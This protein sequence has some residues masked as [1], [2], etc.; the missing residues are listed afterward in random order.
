M[1]LGAPGAGAVPL[2]L[3]V[4][5]GRFIVCVC[6]LL[7]LSYLVIRVAGGGGP[8]VRPGTPSPCGVAAR[9]CSSSVVTAAWRRRAARL[10]RRRT[11]LP[12]RRVGPRRRSRSSSRATSRRSSSSE[13]SARAASCSRRPF[14]VERVPEPTGFRARWPRS[15]SPRTRTCTCSSRRRCGTST[16]RWRRLR[17]ASAAPGGRVLFRVTLPLF[18]PAICRLAPRRPL[19]AVG[20]RRGLADAVRLAHPRDLPPVPQ[21]FDRTPAACS[22]SSSS[23]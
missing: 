11:D 14:G 3:V 13:P 18:R 21:L 17:G 7:P 6:G 5:V 4:A 16:P 15:R 20:L 8:G 2:P 12:G 10:A 9:P 1:S 23:A 19:H 22:P